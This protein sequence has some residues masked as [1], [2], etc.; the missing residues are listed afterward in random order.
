LIVKLSSIGDV[1]QALPVAT[2]LRRRH[3]QALISWAVED[4][5]APLLEAHPAIDRLIAFPPLRWRRRGRRW[6]VR[7]RAAVR[8]LRGQ[9]YDVAVDLQSLAKSSTVALLSA[10]P[11]RIGYARQREGAR[12]VSRPVPGRPGAH[13]VEDYLACARALGAGDATVDFGLRVRAAARARAA[14]LLGDGG[15]C[16]RPLVV[17]NASASRARK[18]WPLE[19]WV[20]LAKALSEVGDVVLVGG[21]ADLRRHTEIARRA[22]RL[23]DLTGRTSLTE[24]AAVLDRSAVHVAH[25]TAT[26]HIA[27]ALGK[28]VAGVYGPT[29][30]R[31]LGPWGERHV[32][33]RGDGPCAAT[34]PQ[35]CPY[36]RRCLTAVT[37]EKVLGATLDLLAACG[38]AAP[39]RAR[40]DARHTGRK[41]GAAPPTLGSRP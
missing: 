7:L 32:A 39:Q 38:S 31:L 17:I 4:W 2:A 18:C 13:V 35:L 37:V 25:D 3:P 15:G 9:P 29:D 27:A 26:A 23:R 5:I 20:E 6:A 30:P 24:L 36:R 14:E 16:D 22:P 40:E 8:E 33:L 1:V 11:R 10:A 12:L 41:A 19:R 28:P 21:A 34:C